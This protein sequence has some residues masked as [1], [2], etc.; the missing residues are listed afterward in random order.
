MAFLGNYY[1]R[2]YCILLAGAISI[3]AQNVYVILSTVPD[4]NKDVALISISQLV[5]R[6][7]IEKCRCLKVLKLRISP[8][9]N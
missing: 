2:R 3:V 5:L 8:E 7:C 4:E 6:E 9:Y 1:N